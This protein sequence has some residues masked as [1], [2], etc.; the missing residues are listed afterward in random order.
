M[1]RRVPCFSIPGQYPPTWWPGSI[2]GLPIHT[3]PGV[4][5]FLPG[6]MPIVI[7]ADTHIL[8][9]TSMERVAEHIAIAVDL[10]VYQQHGPWHRHHDAR[11]T[12]PHQFRALRRE[13]VLLRPRTRNT[14]RQ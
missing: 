11:Q 13:V 12:Q 3:L 2:L 8:V 5:A 14:P 9:R 1:S 10:T 7:P 6:S 4:D